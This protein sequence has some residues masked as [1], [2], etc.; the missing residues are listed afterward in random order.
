LADGVTLVG[1]GGEMTACIGYNK[2]CCVIF[3]LLCKIGKSWRKH[4]QETKNKISRLQKGNRPWAS[5]LALKMSAVNIGRKQS[6]E[7]IAKRKTL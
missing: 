7:T 3:V 6:S 2:C 1:L 5:E 4:T